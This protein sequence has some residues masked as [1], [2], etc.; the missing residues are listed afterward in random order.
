MIFL[1]SRAFGWKK[2]LFAGWR[3]LDVCSSS[4]VHTEKM[5]L[6]F[7]Y[8]KEFFFRKLR[9]FRFVNFILMIFFGCTA[10]FRYKAYPIAS[11]DFHWPA[12]E[13]HRFFRADSRKPAKS[14]ERMDVQWWRCGWNLFRKNLYERGAWERSQAPFF[15]AIFRWQ[16]SY[17]T[18]WKFLIYTLH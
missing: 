11:A 12:S 16:V 8:I 1:R 2:F 13:G 7:Y 17:S 6:L 9:H 14:C 5:V 15:T 18:S 10:Y 3:R 4:P